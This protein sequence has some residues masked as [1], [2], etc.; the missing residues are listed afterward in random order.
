[1]FKSGAIAAFLAA[2]LSPCFAGPAD[3]FEKDMDTMW[4]V[5]WHQSGTATR[6]VRWEQDIKVRVTGDRSAAYRQYTLKALRDV[7]AEAGVKV[8]D[9]TDRNDAETVANVTYEILGNDKLSHAQPC[10]TGLSF[11][12]EAAIELATVQM[13]EGDAMRC[14]YHE[15]MHVMGLRGHPEGDT[16]LSYFTRHTDGLLPLDKVMLKAWYSPRARGGM[17]PFEVMPILADQLVS[18]S[19]NKAVASTQRDRFMARTVEQMEA[20]AAGRGELPEI[21]KRCGK[22]TDSGVKLGRMEMSYF[23]GVAYRQGASVARND[24]H[25]ARWLQR[26]GSLGSRSAQALLGGTSGS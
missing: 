1:M 8:I 23:L 24:T 17:T 22:L 19:R 9:V 26:A 2:A 15:S 18:V 21:L 3:G 25:A 6:L 12:S 11:R 5:M 16:V 4:E 7:A 10:Q 13:R 20:F 14:V